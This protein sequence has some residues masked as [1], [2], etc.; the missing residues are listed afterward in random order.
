MRISVVWFSGVQVH[1]PVPPWRWAV[2]RPSRCLLVLLLALGLWQGPARAQDLTPRA[3]VITPVGSN[4]VVLTYSHLDG[5]VQLNS[6]SPLTDAHSNVD[7]AIASYYHSF[8]LFGHS[9]NFTVSVPYGFGD[10]TG[11]VVEVPKESQRSGSL[12]AIARLGVNLFGGAAMQPAEFMKW[13]QSVLLGAS[14]TIV[15]PTGQYDP[16]RLINF[17]SN[18]WAFKPELG[19]SQRW[20]NW[21]LD[22]YLAGWFF[23]DNSEYFSHN[24]YFPG[25][26]SREQRP[27]GAI[28]AHLSYDVKPRLWISLDANYW[29]GGEVELNGLTN[30]L[31]E[32]R[33]SRLGVTAS[34]PLTAHQSIKLSVSDGAYVRYGGNYR[35]ISLGWQ[36]G[37]LDTRPR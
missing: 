13:R 7:L 25:T 10:F 37:W 35:S 26:Q 9:A 19:Y 14:L 1:D 29:W 3:Y 17:G 18:R 31:T 23:T 4:A 2:L 32:Q 15:A 30:P 36:Y 12:D 8:G 34:V 5:D 24:S 6:A 33:S 11:L 27:V 28:E 20:H 21:V 22:G 16:T